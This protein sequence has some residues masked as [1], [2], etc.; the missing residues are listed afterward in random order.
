MTNRINVLFVC[1]GNICRSPMAQGVFARDVNAAGFAEAVRIDSAGTHAFHV[2]KPPDERGRKAVQKR[3]VDIDT[4][5]AR[6]IEMADF[7]DF[8]YIL[9]MDRQNLD[10]LRYLC[11]P[12]R[13]HALHLFS[14]FSPGLKN[15]EIPDP[16][17]G[18][19]RDFEEVL[20][21]IELASGGLVET[22]GARVL[23]G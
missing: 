2:G 19:E 4:L 18:E 20:D 17:H 13:R 1:M 14:E 16:Y 15:R 12:E 5:E 11:P 22:I 7:A 23:E 21:M 9:A 6:R 8:D 3:R 10:M